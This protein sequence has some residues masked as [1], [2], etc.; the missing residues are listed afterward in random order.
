M[1]VQHG[2]IPLA[3]KESTHRMR[4]PDDG[5]KRKADTMTLSS[6]MTQSHSPDSQ[7][8]LLGIPHLSWP[9]TTTC[10]RS[11]H[12]K[13]FSHVALYYLQSTLKSLLHFGWK[14]SSIYKAFAVQVRRIKFNSSE[15]LQKLGAQWQMLIITELEKQTS[16]FQE[17]V[18]QLAYPMTNPCVS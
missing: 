1:G 17:L 7:G 13:P 8:Y 9:V 14:D 12:E 4:A 6:K 18:G 2:N 5:Q 3:M 10:Y 15:P 16:R 11:L